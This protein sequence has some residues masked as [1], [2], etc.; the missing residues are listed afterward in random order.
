MFRLQDICHWVGPFL[1]L[2]IN[3]P[4][5]SQLF[6]SRY[7]NGSII[8]ATLQPTFTILH[9]LTTSRPPSPICGLSWHGSSSKQKSDMLAT[10]TADGMLRVWSVSKAPH[11]E[12]PRTIRVLDST[13]NGITSRNWF[14]WSKNGRLVNFADG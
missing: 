3:E 14:A 1:L 9:T 8:I 2:I 7:Q 11:T 6:P 12:P 10:Q 13:E 4:N 5:H